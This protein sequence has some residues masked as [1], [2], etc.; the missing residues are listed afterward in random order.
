[1]QVLSCIATLAPAQTACVLMMSFKQNL[2]QCTSP[3]ALDQKNSTTRRTQEV[4]ETIP[5]RERMRDMLKK[6]VSYAT[7]HNPPRPLNCDGLENR[8]YKTCSNSSWGNLPISWFPKLVYLGGIR[9]TKASR[10]CVNSSCQTIKKPPVPS[11]GI[12]GAAHPQG[13]ADPREALPRVACTVW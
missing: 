2:S 1:M 13:S 6:N 10:L 5:R 11:P 7:Q 8:A 9:E 3:E 12:S 4:V